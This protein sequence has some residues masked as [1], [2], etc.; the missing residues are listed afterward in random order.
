MAAKS[1]SNYQIQNIVA[2]AS[3]EKPVP[4]VKLAKN[5]EEKLSPLGFKSDKEFK[6]H[7]TIFRIKNKIDSGHILESIGWNIKERFFA[8]NLVNN[9]LFFTNNT[10]SPKLVPT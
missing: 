10:K 7:I 9:Y 2:T 5:V 3:L 6:P 8:K 1:K 4:L